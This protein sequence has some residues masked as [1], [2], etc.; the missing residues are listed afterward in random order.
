MKKGAD[1]SC[2]ILSSIGGEVEVRYGAAFDYDEKLAKGQTMVLPAELGTYCVE[3]NGVLLY[4]YVPEPDDEVWRGW[5][6]KNG[7]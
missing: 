7:F 5:E 1:G 4:S 6:V 3:G 2:I